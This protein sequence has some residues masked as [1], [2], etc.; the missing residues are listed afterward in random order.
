MQAEESSD[1]RVFCSL[2][3]GMAVLYPDMDK[4]TSVESLGAYYENGPPGYP[5]P[6][7]E[8]QAERAVALGKLTQ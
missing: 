2:M 5:F 8:G 3:W 7:E 4:I 6:S 1:V